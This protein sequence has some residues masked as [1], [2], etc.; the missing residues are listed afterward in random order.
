MSNMEDERGTLE[1]A[2]AALFEDRVMAARRL[3][4]VI[5]ITSCRPGSWRCGSGQARSEN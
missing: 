3:P 2:G 1:E 4:G 5:V